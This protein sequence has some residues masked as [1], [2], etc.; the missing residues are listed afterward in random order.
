MHRTKLAVGSDGRGANRGDLRVEPARFRARSAR[1]SHRRR[2]T[3]YRSGRAR[4]CR[5][6]PDRRARRRAR[7][8]PNAA[9]EG[10]APRSDP[11]RP[12]RVSM[13][14][15]MLEAIADATDHAAPVV[16]QLGVAHPHDV[17]AGIGE[18][19][20]PLHVANHSASPS[21]TVMSPRTLSDCA[22]SSGSRTGT[23]YT[24]R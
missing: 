18:F 22:T 24:G 4:E 15:A 21:D 8:R 13:S 10:P 11:L 20:D 16:E 17:R 12:P 7:Y 14:S 9:G 3:R 2:T 1:L 23:T 19:H 5:R 6:P